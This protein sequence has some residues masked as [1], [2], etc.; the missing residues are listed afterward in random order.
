[1]VDYCEI[2]NRFR[3]EIG[4]KLICGVYV[5]PGAPVILTSSK[6]QQVH[7]HGLIINDGSRLRIFMKI[8]SVK[9]PFEI[10]PR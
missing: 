3:L 10:P 8:N 9:V 2:S 5:Y 7:C 1:M 6:G 4:L